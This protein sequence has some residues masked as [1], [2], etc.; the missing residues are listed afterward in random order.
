AAAVMVDPK[1]SCPDRMNRLVVDDP[2]F[3]FRNVMVELY[4]DR[5]HPAPIDAPAAGPH[6]PSISEHAT[7]HPDASIA[8]GASVHPHVTV[9]AGAAVGTG[10]VLYPGVYVGAQAR[11]GSDCILYPNVVVYDQC[12]VG[13]RVTL[14]ANTVVGQDGFGYATHGGRHHKIPQT[15]V[16]V[17]EDDVELG[18]GCA[19]ERAALGETRIG[20]G[21][22]FADLISI[23]HGTSIGR[24]CLLVS[25]VGVSGSVELGNYVVLGG[26]VGVA[27]HLT[28]G[29]GVQAA[30][31][32][33]IVHDV[34]AGRKIAGVPAIDLDKAKRNALAATEL[35]DLFKRVRRI[36]RRLE[37]APDRPAGGDA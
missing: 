22:K 10:T 16:V 6:E 14:H 35:Y 12:V 37:K 1:T 28:V 25:L 13:D 3:A 32:A 7:V 21:T 17:I 11:V 15:G 18:A 9:E 8:P 30:G 33:A 20:E 26:Q 36:E 29:D 23:G 2:Y 4:G 34:P 27:G 31:K 19:I 24:H 5:P